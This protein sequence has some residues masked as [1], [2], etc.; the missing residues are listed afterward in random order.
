MEEDRE[1]ARRMVDAFARMSVDEAIRMCAADVELTTLF[2]RLGG[3]KLRGHDGLREWFRRLDQLWAFID[4][5]DWRA[6][7][8]GDWVVVTGSARI[9][10]TASP[11]E[12][13][14]EWA[15]AGKIADGRFAKLGVYLNRGEAID[16]VEAD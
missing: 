2:D 9:R 16:A 14:I 10:G 4:I 6:E 7:H 3:P 13:E 5:R 12:M 15:S 8:V 11:Q 1:L